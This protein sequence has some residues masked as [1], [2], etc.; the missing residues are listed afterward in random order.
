LLALLKNVGHNGSYGVPELLA[1]LS[2]NSAGGCTMSVLNSCPGKAHRVRYS[3]CRP[4]I[5]VLRQRT[6]LFAI[7]LLGFGMGATYTN[8]SFVTAPTY[9]TGSGWSVAVADLNGDGHPDIVVAHGEY[10]KQNSASVLLSNGDGTFQAAQ[11]Y[12][13][14]L[15]PGSVAI[16]DLNGDGIP[17]LVVANLNS[18]TVSVLLGN[19]DGTFQ[20]AESYAAG[21]GPDSVVVGDFNGDG[22]L[23][24]AVAN[25]FYSHGTVSILLGNGDGTFLA[26][27]SYAVGD[28]PRSLV[29]G[30]FN[31]DGIPDL[32]VAADI[33]DHQSMVVSILLGNGDGTFQPAQNYAVGH[34]PGS[35]AVGDFNG[36]GHVDLAVANQRSDNV[37]VLL[38]NGDGTFQAAQNYSVGAIP[39]SLAVGDFNGDGIPDL[40]VANY[41]SGTVSILLGRGDGTFQTSLVSYTVSDA[42][43]SLAVGDFNGDGHLDLAVGG[44]SK[45]SILLGKGDATFQAAPSY[46]AGNYAPSV[47][48]RDF[49]GD[50]ILDL[51][52][53]NPSSGTVS[54]LL[55]NVDG[56]FQ[57]AQ[58]YAAGNGPVSLAVADFNGDGNLDLAVANTDSNSVNILLG[59]GD[60][61]FQAPQSYA[62]AGN[63]A[64]SVATGDF[65]G[66]G[67]PDLAVVAF[68][69]T[70]AG[71]VSVL[72]GNGDGTFQAAVSFSDGYRATSVAVG[73]FNG[74]G[75][76]DIVTTNFDWT[77]GGKFH[78]PQITESDVRVFLGNGDGTF[79][80][81]QIYN[82]PGGPNSVALGDFNGDGIPDLA[83][84]QY[85]PIDGQ[86]MVSILLGNGDGTFHY[87]QPY[88]G[89]GGFGSSVAVGDFNADGKTDLVVTNSG[90]NGRVVVL[91]GNGDGTFQHGQP[92][93]AANFLSSVA[94]GDFNR[95]G[96]P[97]LAVAND[98]SP[99]TVTVLLNAADWGR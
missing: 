51:A 73:D 97:D 11:S 36:D 39:V 5:E 46:G 60:G 4:P 3:F 89:A 59:N 90:F 61:S 7:T 17:D 6:L 62:V 98:L 32:A 14:G 70:I 12:Q 40:A 75:K 56:S 77:P 67:I 85:N 47:A 21:S 1:T 33:N 69:D 24:I 99:A 34:G 42:P 25:G 95:D 86:S 57:A 35:L 38:G 2:S 30:D 81:P 27:Q 26:P 20:R 64:P 45:T 44:I 28:S 54:I 71:F 55:G 65:N 63:Y 91:L 50:G 13:V 84:A 10:E 16:R 41:N 37:S 9:A 68:D 15:G 53:T 23:D 80:A 93:G 48:V 82:V 29:I 92:Y 31:G 74:D 49:N 58:S 66:D 76:D 19:G 88:P 52:V 72:L 94:V 78:P 22:K 8:A 18:G 96:Y 43:Q 79:Q 83:V 87:A